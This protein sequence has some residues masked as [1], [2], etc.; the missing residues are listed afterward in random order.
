MIL[1]DDADWDVEIKEQVVRA[2][3]S[4][5]K[6]TEPGTEDLWGTEWDVLY[7]GHCGDRYGA[8]SVRCALSPRSCE[9]SP[10]V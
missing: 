8:L 7:L 10:F 1:E 4:L 9:V 6:L 3:D 2:Q 5:R